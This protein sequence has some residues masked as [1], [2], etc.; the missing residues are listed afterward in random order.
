MRKPASSRPGTMLILTVYPPNE[1][2]GVNHAIQAELAS[3]LAGQSR[4]TNHGWNK[5]G[6]MWM[7]QPLK[8]STKGSVVGKSG[9]HSGMH[10]E[11]ATFVTV[12]SSPRSR[13][14]PSLPV[15]VRRGEEIVGGAE[16]HVSVKIQHQLGGQGHWSRFAPALR[17]Q[18]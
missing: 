14:Y 4:P 11:K 13:R 10:R 16:C 7:A 2:L 9:K 18:Q 6:A 17:S 15:C 5:V 8:G 12:L 1:T 3:D